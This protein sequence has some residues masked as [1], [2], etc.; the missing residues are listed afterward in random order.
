MEGTLEVEVPDST[1]AKKTDHNPPLESWKPT[2][3]ISV[4]VGMGP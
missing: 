2:A 3:V 1:I 4:V